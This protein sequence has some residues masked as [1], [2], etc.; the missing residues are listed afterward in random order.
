MAM[1]TVIGFTHAIGRTIVLRPGAKMF[2]LSNGLEFHDFFHLEAMAAK[3][4]GIDF[5]ICFPFT[6]PS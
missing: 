5:I 6:M 1:E 2:L 4:D 3:H